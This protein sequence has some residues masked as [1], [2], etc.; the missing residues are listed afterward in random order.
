MTL[1]GLR[2][3]ITALVAAVVAACVTFAFAAVYTGTA[4]ELDHRS[5]QDLRS[6]MASL[7]QVVSTGP[8]GAAAIAA[9][10]RGYLRQQPFRPTSRVL[11]VQ[12][13]GG[14]T[15]TNEPELLGFATP[16]E[17][18]TASEQARENRA[19]HE[20]LT[21]PT[22]FSRHELPDG[23]HVELLVHAVRRA[24]RLVARAGVAEPTASND[25]AGHA[26]RDEFV[27]AGALALLAAVGGGFAVASR[28][29]APL[30]RMAR[31][32][33]RVD[34]GDLHP[35]MHADGRRDEVRV[36]AEAFDRM[37]DR[38]QRAFD[39][40][41]AFVADASHE[42]RTPLTVIRGQLETLALAED[43]DANDVRRVET[44]VRV[45]VD[46]MTRLVDDMLTLA[47]ADEE[48]FLRCAP[49]ELKGFVAD[50]VHGLEHATGRRLALAPVPHLRIEADEGRLAQALRNLVRN[51]M[52]HTEAEGAVA[53]AVQA[54]DG[55]VRFMVDDDGPG[56]PEP[57]RAAIFDRFHRLDGGRASESAGAGLGLAI[58][59]AIATAHGGRVW[60]DE[61]PI[62]GARLVLELPLRTV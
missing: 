21:A 14:R 33:A 6:D 29:A 19:G 27:L 32:A 13:V 41:S 55:H 7:E 61:A 52:S 46:R 25:R 37:L 23:G 40:Q 22:G 2:P 48:G 49:I 42:L 8:T 16:D 39:R 17:D 54:D 28:V 56:I 9:R 10:S 36:L 18:E 30:R 38:L 45:E 35:R 53:L 60:A 47:A 62:G 3:R 57:A 24:G 15:L 4:A 20:V 43:P 34:A 59:Q 50:L 5:R 31:V 51:A 12:P 26:L 44:L 58:V 11:F 1:A